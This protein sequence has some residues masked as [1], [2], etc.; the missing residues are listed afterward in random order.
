MHCHFRIRIGRAPTFIFTLAPEMPQTGRGLIR[1]LN[2]VFS[3]S[4][5]WPTQ[6]HRATHTRS[7]NAKVNTQNSQM[8]ARDVSG[9]IFPLFQYAISRSQRSRLEFP[10]TQ[11]KPRAFLVQLCDVSS[12]FGLMPCWLT[13]Q[14]HSGLVSVIMCRPEWDVRKFCL[15]LNDAVS[16]SYVLQ[17]WSC[18]RCTRI[19][20]EQYCDL[21]AYW[22]SFNWVEDEESQSRC[23]GRVGDWNELRKWY[24]YTG[25]CWEMEHY[26]IVKGVEGR[27]EFPSVQS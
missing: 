9:K 10:A 11:Q 21:S 1:I 5:R 16:V 8:T 20:V 17:R 7:I 12:A 27:Y 15:S 19:Y 23:Q 14:C 22:H 6:F 4:S 24:C 26:G 18:A 3:V 13:G 2:N 25:V